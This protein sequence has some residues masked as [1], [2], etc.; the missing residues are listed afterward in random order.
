MYYKI[1]KLRSFSVC[2]CV[3]WM[4]AGEGAGVYVCSDDSCASSCGQHVCFNYLSLY[5]VSLML[6][7]IFHHVHFIFVLLRTDQMQFQGFVSNV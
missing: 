3:V 6:V 4:G 1:S 5:T 7:A 2:V